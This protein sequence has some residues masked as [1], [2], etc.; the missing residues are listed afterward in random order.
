M[1]IAKMKEQVV[2]YAT[3][4]LKLREALQQLFDECV[5]ADALGELSEAITG[6]TLDKVRE[7]LNTAE[8]SVHLTRF[9]QCQTCEYNPCDL[10]NNS[11]YC[12]AR[13]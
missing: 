4:N 6:E 5:I 9:P 11:D 10:A 7:A 12:P 8:Q 13:K 2:D 3:S 1:S